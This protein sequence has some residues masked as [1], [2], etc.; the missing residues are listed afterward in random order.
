M[1][2]GRKGEGEA[3]EPGA[4]MHMHAGARLRVRGWPWLARASKGLVLQRGQQGV[5]VG[6]LVAVRAHGGACVQ[7]A[8]EGG[9]AGPG[10]G[11]SV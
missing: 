4:A 6:Q 10:R 1:E 7:R 9:R 5:Q 11:R 3:A 2:V 8:E